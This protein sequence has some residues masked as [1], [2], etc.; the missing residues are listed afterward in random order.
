MVDTKLQTAFAPRLGVSHPLSEN[1][2]IHFFY[3]HFY[4]RPSYTKQIGFPFINFTEDMATVRDPYAKQYTYMDQWHGYYG[5]PFMSYEKTIQY[6]VGFDQNI[7]N[8]FLLKVAGFYKDATNEANSWTRLYAATNQYN[9]PI[10]VSNS[11]Y[12]DVRGIEISL[13]SR[14]N[15]PVNFGITHELYWSWLGDVGYSDMFE[16][17]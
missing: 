14:F 12:S 9:T 10:M 6:E 2:V 13:D 17:I 1:T 4:Q 3:G 15:H 7:E 11:N 5:N 8:L 16:P